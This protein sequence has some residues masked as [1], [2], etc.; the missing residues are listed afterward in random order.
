MIAGKCRLT[1]IRNIAGGLR[2]AMSSQMIAEGTK[3]LM[4]AEIRR[5]A[6]SRNIAEGSMM[7]TF[8]GIRDTTGEIAS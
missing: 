8:A 5:L 2:I 7:T 3:H 4:I 1:R 6:I